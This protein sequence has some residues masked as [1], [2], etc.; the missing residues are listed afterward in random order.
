M[1][2]PELD[3]VVPVYNE[4]A[5]IVGLL[6]SLKKHVSA[7]FRVLVCYDF[8]EDNTLP[9][10]A[11]RRPDGL[12][13]VLV[14][15]LKSGPAGAVVTGLLATTAPAVLVYPADDDY[16]AARIDAL[17]A[18]FRSGCDVVCA[19]RFAGGGK[20]VGYPWLKSV[21]VRSAGAALYYLADF[22]TTD[23]TNGLRLFSGR[24]ARTIVV[25]T[26]VGH[27]YSI[28]LLAKCLRLGWRVGEVPVEWHE[29]TQ[30]KSRFRVLQWLPVYAGWFAYAFATTYLH[31]GP[32]TVPRRI[33]SAI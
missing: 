10:V 19:N 21:L 14:K 8:D 11:M 28:E 12:D 22:P 32:P 17:M 31:R 3:I 2:P 4:G 7:P 26:N 25:E 16:N 9:A 24:A 27:A 20:I 33:I 6:D 13:V 5:A 1:S 15:N 30:G 18:V 23:P 29:R